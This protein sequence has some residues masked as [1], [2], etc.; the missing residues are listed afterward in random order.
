MNVDNPLLVLGV[1]IFAIIMFGIIARA[2][3]LN[4]AIKV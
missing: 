1:Q 2:Y 3:I 4:A